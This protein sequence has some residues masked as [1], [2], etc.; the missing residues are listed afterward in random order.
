MNKWIRNMLVLCMV[1]AW[2]CLMPGKAYATESNSDTPPTVVN[3]QTIVEF[4]G[5]PQDGGCRITWETIPDAEVYAIL[6]TDM[7]DRDGDKAGNAKN[8]LLKTIDGKAI[9]QNMY[10]VA[11]VTDTFADLEIN[12]HRSAMVQVVALKKCNEQGDYICVAKSNEKLIYTIPTIN[13]ENAD[14]SKSVKEWKKSSKLELEVSFPNANI[15]TD[16]NSKLISYEMRMKNAKDKIVWSKKYSSANTSR[17][18][19]IKKGAAYLIEARASFMIEGKIYQ[20]QWSKPYVVA[21][22]KKL[23]YT[24]KKKDKTYKVKVTWKS[25]KNTVKYKINR[26]NY[27]KNKSRTRKKG[28]FTTTYT[29][30]QLRGGAYD[31]VVPYVKVKRNGRWEILPAN[32]EIIIEAE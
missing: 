15:S 11:V 30:K 26:H 24:C 21:V 31:A 6:T 2:V 5:E 7:D 20:S 23:T 13:L 22:P 8:I 14:F 1:C 27:G 16:S 32:T 29:K 3:G 4:V 28:S 12:C 9:D 19:T 17:K 10:F 18:L 25:I